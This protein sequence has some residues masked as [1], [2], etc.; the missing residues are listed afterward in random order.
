MPSLSERDTVDRMIPLTPAVFH[1]LLSLAQGA[2]HG[3]GVIVDVRERTEGKIR[4]GTGTLY[5]ALKRLL[6][7]GA[8]HETAPPEAPEDAR[9]QMHYSITPLGTELLRAETA[10]LREMVA[11]ATK[12]VAQGDPDTSS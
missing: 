10:R 4:L 5:T 9:R 6:D 2:R 8:I 3:Y 7:Q 1:I 11:L 12:V